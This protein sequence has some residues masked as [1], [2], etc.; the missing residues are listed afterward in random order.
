[1]QKMKYRHVGR[2][3]VQVSEIGLGSWQ[4][5]GHAVEKAQ[6]EACINRAYELGINFFD[7]ADAY[8]G[9]EAEKVVGA[10]LAKFPRDSYVLST[11][12]Y[13]PMGPICSKAVTPRSNVWAPTTSICIS[14]IAMTKARRSKRPCARSTIWRNRA[15]F[16]ITAS[17]NGP[18]ARFP[19]P[20]ASRA[21]A[22]FSPWWSTSR[23]TACWRAAL[24]AR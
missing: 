4:T 7:T 11:K 18:A 23:N 12:I 9:G 14:A 15:R 21:R 8:A 19:R 13:F 22:T 16:C 10:A 20:P 3:G 1:M 5:Y 6:A 2:S 17:L 24:N